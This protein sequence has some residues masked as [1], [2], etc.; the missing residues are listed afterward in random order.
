MGYCYGAR[1]MK[2][3]ENAVYVGGLIDVL[4]GV[5]F[6]AAF[7]M[8]RRA[9][10]SFFLEEN[11]LIDQAASFLWVIG[12]SAPM[13]GIT[14]IVTSYFQAL[15]KAFNSMIITM[16]RNV[17]LFIP[18]VI[19]MNLFWKLSGVIATQPVVETIVAAMSIILYVI[20]KRKVIE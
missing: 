13:L 5:F 4:I 19:V 11:Q 14:N 18:G 16:L 15:G 1:Q 10:V 6:T 7:I 12:L 9:L 17:I 20:N 2:R 3:L 8:F